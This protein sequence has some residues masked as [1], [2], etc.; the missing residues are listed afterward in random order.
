MAH[1]ETSPLSLS[2]SAVA[3]AFLPVVNKAGK[4]TATAEKVAA[5]L[6]AASPAALVGHAMTSRGA[7]GKQA[8]RALASVALTLDNIRALDT[9]PD[10]ALWGD[11]FSLLRGTYGVADYN[12]ATMR[13]KGGALAYMVAVEAT[14][15]QR[16][17]RAETVKAQTAAI[18]HLDA[19]RVDLDH[20][21]RLYDLSE[22]AR[23]AAEQTPEAT[24]EATPD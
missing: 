24:P 15:T 22:A 10:G 21:R 20:V 19:V 12:R 17:N 23:I 7:I 11:I 6:N 1:A 8:R 5:T 3:G 9:A 13:G 14:A 4:V 16:F 18:D 2:L